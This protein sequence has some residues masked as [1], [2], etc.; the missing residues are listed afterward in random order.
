M[1][2]LH[3]PRTDRP[4]SGIANLS[5]VRR[6]FAIAKNLELHESS[7][8]NSLTP[9]DELFFSLEGRTVQSGAECW[10]VEVCGV[11][12]T[13]SHYWVQMNLRGSV[14]YGITVRSLVPDPAG[15]LET[16]RDWLDDPTLD[17]LDFPVLN[18]VVGA[19][20]RLMGAAGPD[21]SPAP[22]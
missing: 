13:P 11:H 14:S 5:S 1:R 6:L 12:S 8:P 22:I 21:F 20:V 19:T 7:G 4:G 15:L 18:K 9:S 16:L 17:D 10:R 3:E 2:F